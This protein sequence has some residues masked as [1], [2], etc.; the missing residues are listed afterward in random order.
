MKYPQLK[1]VKEI[2]IDNLVKRIGVHKEAVKIV[3]EKRNSGDE[4]WLDE[5]DC[6][7]DNWCNIRKILDKEVSDS[8][9]CIREIS[10]QLLQEVQAFISKES[11]MEKILQSDRGDIYEIEL[12]DENGNICG[13]TAKS[14]FLDEVY[15]R[16]IEGL[17]DDAEMIN[18]LFSIKLREYM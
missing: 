9:D 17:E 14:D 18:N 4:W 2:V 3:N 10:P 11:S 6:V 15:P 1:E 16:Y 13:E 8:L 5:S 12:Q 7:F